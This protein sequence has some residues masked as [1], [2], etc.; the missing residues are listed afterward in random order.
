M[1]ESSRAA[2]T[3]KLSDLK[4]QLTGYIMDDLETAQLIR[5]Y[6]QK[7]SGNACGITDEGCEMCSG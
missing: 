7:L 3:A 5:H 1:T 2:M 4:G 6:E